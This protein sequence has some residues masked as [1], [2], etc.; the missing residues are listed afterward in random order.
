MERWRDLPR[1]PQ[2][3]LGKVGMWTLLFCSNTFIS[4]TLHNVSFKTKTEKILPRTSYN[5]SCAL[6][7]LV[8]LKSLSLGPLQVEA[9]ILPLSTWEDPLLL[10]NSA[11]LN[12][13]S[14]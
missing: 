5:V 3:V 2:L 9:Q 12:P 10:I 8:P 1:V 4:F 14:L 7:P 11:S 13:D 6:A